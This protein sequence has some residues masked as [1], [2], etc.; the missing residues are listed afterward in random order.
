MYN[1]M[2]EK[3]AASDLVETVEHAWRYWDQN[4]I[5]FFLERAVVH[6]ALR[7]KI[8]LSLGKEASGLD[9]RRALCDAY[10]VLNPYVRN[11]IEQQRM[12]VLA[13]LAEVLV[14]SRVFRPESLEPDAS[15]MAYREGA[16]Y[17]LKF[18]VR[19]QVQAVHALCNG[20]VDDGGFEGKV[21]PTFEFKGERLGLPRRRV[22]QV[23]STGRRRVNGVIVDARE[24]FHGFK[25]DGTE[26]TN[27]Y[28]VN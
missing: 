15:H 26:A 11:D 22:G 28:Q 6:R 10:Q 2:V 7:K 14:D 20:F 4:K 23:L 8:A 18:E 17:R 12:G 21:V 1:N 13:D 5:L 24:V 25:A 3:L 9:I 19:G 27:V 16:I